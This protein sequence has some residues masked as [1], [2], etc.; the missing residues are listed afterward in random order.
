MKQKHV[1]APK[2]TADSQNKP[3]HGKTSKDFGHSQGNLMEMTDGD[4]SDADASNVNKFGANK[5]RRWNRPK[6][7]VSVKEMEKAPT[8]RSSRIYKLNK[9][10]NA[11]QVIII[12]NY[13][14]LTHL[15]NYINLNTNL[16]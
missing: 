2:S 5:T 3:L 16:S 15:I 7:D 14:C 1:C 13:I 6:M 11:S 12:S 8:R 10:K 4:S 9:E